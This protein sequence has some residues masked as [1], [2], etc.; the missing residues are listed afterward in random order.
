MELKKRKINRLKCYDYSTPGLYFLTI[1]IK[2]KKQILW[3]N[4]SKGEQYTLS[5][6]GKIIEQ[7]IEK[8]NEAYSENINIDKYVIM[9]NHIHIII[10]INGRPQVAPTISRVINQFQGAV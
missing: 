7:E 9:P 8:M 5:Y 3:Q 10:K 6:Y 4:Y 2:D 1:C